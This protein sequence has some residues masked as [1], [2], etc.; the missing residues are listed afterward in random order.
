MNDDFNK[1][2]SE[3]QKIY[4]EDPKRATK[5]AS[6]SLKRLEAKKGILKDIDLDILGICTI[7]IIILLLAFID[8]ETLP[9]YMAGFAFFLS[10]HF[11]GM[12]VKGFGLIFLF[13][14][15]VTGICMMVGETLSKVLGNPLFSDNPRN[16]IIYLVIAIA[17]LVIA[18]IIVILHNLSDNLK[19]LNHIKLL[20]LTI[21][22][23]GFLM[24]KIFPFIIQ[25]I[26]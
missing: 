23:I 4:A 26:Y 3:L 17:L 14:H 25:Y 9:L 22:F 11:V 10:G 19:K 6:Q 2:I 5:E 21:Y 8:M 18:T 12:Y 13:S 7:S 1:Y 24:I 20:P 16:L 15:S